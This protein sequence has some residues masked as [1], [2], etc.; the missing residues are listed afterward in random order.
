MKRRDVLKGLL[1]GAALVVLPVGA[2]EADAK[3]TEEPQPPRCKICGK[4]QKESQLVCFI[5][6]FQPNEAAEMAWC[7]RHGHFQCTVTD[8]MTGTPV[9]MTGPVFAIPTVE[10]FPEDWEEYNST[11][12]IEDDGFDW[13]RDNI[14]ALY[15]DG[16]L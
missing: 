4:T 5:N 15:K 1:T 3:E 10:L 7:C 9:Y 2:K 12:V 14:V 8:P 13:R 11:A 6:P 16:K